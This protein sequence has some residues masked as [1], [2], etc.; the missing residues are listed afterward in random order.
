MEKIY[1]YINN[2]NSN[3]N[4][5]KK[6][7]I[8]IIIMRIQII[9]KRRTTTTNNNTKKID[10]DILYNADMPKLW[11]LMYFFHVFL[12]CK[13]FI[14]KFGNPGWEQRLLSKAQFIY[15]NGISFFFKAPHT[16]AKS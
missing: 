6:I 5:I 14:W 7:L 13:Y 15:D 3:N 2:N 12:T 8:L 9:I 1:I 10:D 11:A 16:N 4:I